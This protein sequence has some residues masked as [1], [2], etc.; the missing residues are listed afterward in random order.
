MITNAKTIAVCPECG[1]KT[2][3]P[4]H[5]PICTVKLHCRWYRCVKCMAEF[6]MEGRYE[7][8]QAVAK[9]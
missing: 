3:M 8:I 6:C 4:C 7:K 9:G 2:L 5:Y 1:C